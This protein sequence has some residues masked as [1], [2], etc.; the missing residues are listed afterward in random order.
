MPNFIIY[1]TFN[2]IEAAR[3]LASGLIKEKLIAC[4]NIYPQGES[5]YFWE[6][7]VQNESEIYVILKTTKNNYNAV[8]SYIKKH[9]GYDVPCIWGVEI[10]KMSREYSLWLSGQVKA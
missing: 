9:H 5:Y 7:K 8:E 2:D 4:A 3:K 10:D 6:D 1:T